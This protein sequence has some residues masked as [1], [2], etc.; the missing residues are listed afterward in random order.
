ML[1]AEMLLAT[2]RSMIRYLGVGKNVK[3][4]PMQGSGSIH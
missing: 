2:V 1:K 3:A 4:K